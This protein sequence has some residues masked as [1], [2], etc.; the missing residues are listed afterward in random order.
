MN[1][2][3][4]IIFF[5][6]IIIV[7]LIFTMKKVL[8][9]PSEPKLTFL[10][11]ENKEVANNL[12]I[13][14]R[15]INDVNNKESKEN[16]LVTLLENGVVY[17]FENNDDFVMYEIFIKQDEK[18]AY[19]GGENIYFVEDE[20]SIR[21]G[22]DRK[23]AI[24]IDSRTQ[25]NSIVVEYRQSYKGNETKNSRIVKLSASYKF[26]GYIFHDKTDLSDFTSVKVEKNI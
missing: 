7:L 23:G 22:S 24:L 8:T 15:K 16:K 12:H 20:S 4:F 19:I 1:R 9:M 3:K 6:S 11:M 14:V 25:N 26:N 18:F 21:G 13:N 17:P 2:A 10:I 5:I